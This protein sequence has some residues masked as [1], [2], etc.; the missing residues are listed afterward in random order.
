MLVAIRG[1]A[2]GKWFH[3]VGGLTLVVL[4]SAMLLFAIPQ[5]IRGHVAMAPLALSFPAVSILNLNILGKMS[6]GAFSGCE[7]VTVFSGE[8]RDPNAALVIRKSV[9]IAAPIVTAI[10]TLGTSA[11]LVFA[12]PDQIDLVSP[13]AQNLSL[14]ART[15][16]LTAHVVPL[17]MLL[18]LVSRAGSGTLTLNLVSRLPAGMTCCLHGSPGCIPSTARRWVPSSL[19]AP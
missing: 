16:G 8:C 14:G 7:A 1:L 6:F 12:A 2:L 19:S 13:V 3:N 18:M 17:A 15:L 5:W 4:F 10:F 11:I 9:W